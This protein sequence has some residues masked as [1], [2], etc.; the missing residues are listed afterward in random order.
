[1]GILILGDD[2]TALPR[3]AGDTSKKNGGSVCEF[4]FYPNRSCVELNSTA[5]FVLQ[6]PMSSTY[7]DF[8]VQCFMLVSLTSCYPVAASDL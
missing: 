1:M 7:R 6:G 5:L 8:I 2:T 3:N 4:F